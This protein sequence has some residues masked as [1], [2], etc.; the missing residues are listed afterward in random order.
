MY[1]EVFLFNHWWEYCAFITS[2]IY[3]TNLNQNLKF[4]SKVGIWIESSWSDARKIRQCLW[5]FDTFFCTIMAI[6][7]EWHTS[8]SCNLVLS[9]SIVIFLH[10]QDSNKKE[11]YRHTCT[12]Y[13]KVTRVSYEWEWGNIKYETI[14]LYSLIAQH[15]LNFFLCWLWELALI[16]SQIIVSRVKMFSRQR[17]AGPLLSRHDKN[18][19]YWI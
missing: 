10:H 14:I 9:S 18:T 2:T 12:C 13:V 17:K 19:D 16:S 3:L 11:S 15:S 6:N 8:S 4:E 1:N 7:S 5:S